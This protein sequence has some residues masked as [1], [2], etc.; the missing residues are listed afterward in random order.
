MTNSKILISGL[1]NLE[2]TLQV[3]SFPLEYCPVR[4]PFFGVN[5][6]I[7]GVGFNIAK[8]LTHLGNSCNF[9]SIVGNDPAGEIAKRE[10]IKNRIS[11]EFIAEVLPK[12]PHSVILYDKSG[13]RQINV[14]LKE[15]QETKFP[16][17]LFSIAN[18]EI[19]LAVL[20][21]INFSRTF[22]ERMKV[23][24]IPIATDVHAI[25]DIHDSYNRDF[26]RYADILFMS[27]ELLPVPPV[28]WIR[29]VQMEFGTPIIVIGCGS[30]GAIMGEKGSGLIRKL[31]AV[32]TRPVSN[33]IGAGDALFSCFIHFFIQ[34]RDPWESL[35]KAMI[36][37]SWKIGETGAAHG[38]LSTSALETKLPEFSNKL[39]FEDV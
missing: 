19:S 25:S 22:L 2:V 10:L 18:K 31:P 28:E 35:R 12:T 36:F 33:T 14:D 9:L 30:K 37:A 34:T 39:I 20:C 26:M 1:I 15:V 32:F 24:G 4:Y 38:F 23:R 7:S 17:E 21:N 27:D 3:D 16:E 13:K 5:S 29:A 6:S 8:A 11:T